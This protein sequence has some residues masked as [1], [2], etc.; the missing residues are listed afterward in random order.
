MSIETWEWSY[1]GEA[2]VE[3]IGRNSHSMC[4]LQTVPKDLTNVG[5]NNKTE[6]VLA[7]F[8]GASPENG[9]LGDTLYATLPPVEQ[10]GM[11]FTNTICLPLLC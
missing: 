11:A 5:I 9:P 3:V 7:I 4:I 10:I 2:G 6:S 1:V 8:G